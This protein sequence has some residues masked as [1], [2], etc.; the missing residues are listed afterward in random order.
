MQP[1]TSSSP[2]KPS[3]DK[4]LQLLRGRSGWARTIGM[5]FR[6]SPTTCAAFA[7]VA[8]FTLSATAYSQEVQQASV[9]VSATRVDMQDTDAPYASEVHTRADIE[10][11]GVS[12][13]YDFLAQQT[14]LQIAPSFGNRYNP[15]ISMRGYGIDG[16]QNLV[17]TVDGRRLNTAEVV[18]Q[19]IGGVALADIDR[20]EITKGSGAVLFGDSA[21][22]G[23]IQIY[24][25]PRDHA[26]VD[27]Y[28]GSDGQRGAVAAVGLVRDK[29]DL[30]ATADHS[31][32]NGLS[33]ADANGHTDQSEANI[34]RV[35]AGAQPIAALKLKAEMGGAKIDTRYP[36]SLTLQQLQT[37]PAANTGPYTQQ[38]TDSQYWSVSADYAMNE[39]WKLSVQHHQQD[40][41]TT[42]FW[43]G[44]SPSQSRTRSISNE[45]ALQFQKDAVLVNAGIQ[46]TDNKRLGT[47]DH[48][49]KDNQGLFVQGQYVLDS[50][51]LSTG[52]RHEKV[53]YRYAPINGAALDAD[54]HLNA[55][56]LG[57]NHRISSQ[58]SLFANYSDAFNAPDI[59]RFFN[60]GQFNRF[61]EPAKARTL[62]LG[63]NHITPQNRLK[64]SVFYAKLRNEIYYYSAVSWLDSKNTNIDKSHKYG[65]ELQDR[66]QITPRVSA[67]VNYAWTRAII[68]RENEGGGAFN[69]K[70][71]PGVSRHSMV[72]GLNVRVAQNSHLA[73]TH[74]WR[75]SAWAEEDLANNNRQKQ[76]AYQ[77]TDVSYRHQV[78]QQVE[79]YGSV[80]NLF[81]RTNGIWVGDDNIYP[82]NFER[83]WKL[84][85]RISF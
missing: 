73:L 12:N 27:S 9:L 19:L 58:L 46:T 81:A 84:G 62:T 26:N 68:D 69:G 23:T 64:A 61:I 83:T 45:L 17:I 20:I 65:L 14:S 41:D 71:L 42:T 43:S 16:Y 1:C 2:Q 52:L 77:S 35:A 10:R 78:G 31:Q 80:S 7:T 33:Q 8:T 66:Y 74:T 29:F 21:T 34:W 15:K 63:V 3:I 57:A 6:F 30:S 51:T 53:S 48:T 60:N 67:L 50:W 28:M 18:P 49:S 56:E 13:L 11:S 4:Y 36:G 70:E 5:L 40:K 44:Y 75:S 37:N 22:S 79:L 38:K 24:T 76:R 72:L 82:V 54:T 59:D 32:S 25:K 47:S 55:W 39:E 85:A